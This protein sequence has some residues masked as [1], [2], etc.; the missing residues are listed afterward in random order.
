MEGFGYGNVNKIFIVIYYEVYSVVGK[1][2]IK[3][4]IIKWI[5]VVINDMKGKCRVFRVFRRVFNLVWEWGK[6]FGDVEI[7]WKVEMMFYIG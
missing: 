3:Y 5:I 1:I 2:D 6:V 4:Y 7:K